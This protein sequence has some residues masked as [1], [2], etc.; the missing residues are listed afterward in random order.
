MDLDVDTAQV[1]AASV[2]TL[3]GEIDVYTAPRLRQ[4]II[5]LVDGG[6]SQ[7]II[8]MSAV[9]FLDS[10]GLGVLVGGLKRVRV[11][12]GSLSIVT[13]QDKILKIFDITGLNKVFPIHDSVDAATSQAS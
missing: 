12:D 1:G 4:S 6:A 7:I 13:S 11:K 10:T 2:L 9:D 5:D 8:D 3:R